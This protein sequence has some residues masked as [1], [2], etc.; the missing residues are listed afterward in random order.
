MNGSG[1]SR[2]K[3]LLIV[4]GILLV[5]LGGIYAVFHNQQASNNNPH[6]CINQTFTLGSSGNCIT[7]GQRLLNWY[8]YGIDGP[9]YMSVN[10]DFSATTQAVVQKA[11]S[12]ASL[13]VTGKLDPVTWKLL[14]EE[15]DTPSWWASAA[16]NAGCP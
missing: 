16:K 6:A 10:G 11:Q 3:K 9:S 1:E 4:I 2:G 5:V 12:G 7:D 13:P 8:V 14:C 15:S